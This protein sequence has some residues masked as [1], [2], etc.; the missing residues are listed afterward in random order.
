MAEEKRSTF[1]PNQPVEVGAFFYWWTTLFLST[2]RGGVSISGRRCSPAPQARSVNLTVCSFLAMD[3]PTEAAV[4]DPVQCTPDE[5]AALP[6]VTSLTPYD[7][8]PAGEARIV[9]EGE[10]DEECRELVEYI[11]RSRRCL[12]AEVTPL[13]D[14][15]YSQLNS[16]GQLR[17]RCG[18]CARNTFFGWDFDRMK[19]SMRND[20]DP[21]GLF[22]T[23][24]TALAFGFCG[25]IT[26]IF[27]FMEPETGRKPDDYKYKDIE[28]ADN[29]AEG[30]DGT[31]NLAA[32][33]VNA[34]RWFCGGR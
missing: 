21:L 20:V 10:E 16:E 19:K 11:V 31:L 7:A 17:R 25:Y 14:N 32:N 2:T 18:S 27:Y 5:L 15:T 3:S 26:T 34:G 1:K 28:D 9:A 6:E 4:V 8:P 22:L 30:A 33:A 29:L 23:V 12:T 13:L 24:V